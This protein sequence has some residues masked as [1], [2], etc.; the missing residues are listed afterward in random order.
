MY[1]GI[2]CSPTHSAYVALDDAGEMVWFATITSTAA[3]LKPPKKDS[4]SRKR[5]TRTYANHHQ[6]APKEPF[7]KDEEGKHRELLWSDATHRTVQALIPRGSFVA[8]EDFA[9]GKSQG[10]HQIG[11]TAGLVRCGLLSMDHALRLYDPSSVKIFGTGNGNADKDRI[12]ECV[13]LRHDMHFDE[14]GLGKNETGDLFDAYLIAR[15]VMT[16]AKVRRH[17]W[18]LADLNPD[19]SRIFLRVTKSC[20]VNLLDRPFIVA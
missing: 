20:P 16:E 11:M 8:M 10:A 1:V 17:E 3:S 14:L 4:G 18:S 2:D 12:E 15:M 6:Y 13:K 7:C 19:E 9:Y 5:K